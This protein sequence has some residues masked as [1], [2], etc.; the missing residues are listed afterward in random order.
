MNW[1][2]AADNPEVVEFGPVRGLSVMGRGEPGGLVYGTSAGALYAVAGALLGIAARHG[3]AFEMPVL[4][5]R[6]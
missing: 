1:Y 6:W 3:Q 2:S 5:G 4:E